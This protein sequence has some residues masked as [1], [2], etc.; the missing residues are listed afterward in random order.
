MRIF[1]SAA[2]I[3]SDLQAEKILRAFLARFPDQQI[4]IFGIGGPALRTLPG[5]KALQN[6]ESMRAMGFVEVLSRIFFFKQIQTRIVSELERHPPDV[7]LTF[8]Y[9]D[10]HFSLMKRLK[11]LSWF[12]S[13]LRICGIPPK[14]WVWR[15]GR[16][17][18]IAELYS[19][20]WVIFPFEKDFYQSHGI[21]VI[22]EGNPL[23]ADLVRNA[24]PK[25]PLIEGDEVRIAV[26]PGSREGELKAHLP[27]LGPTLTELSQLLGK[28]VHAEVPIPLG[29]NEA[30]V[31][32]ELISTDRVNYRLILGGSGEVLSRNSLGLIKSGTSTLEAAVLG[33]VPVIFYRMNPISEWIFRRV[34]HYTGPVGLPNILL[35]IHHRARS[36]FPEL[37]GGEA[38][39]DLLATAL[40]RLIDQPE[41][42]DELR[43]KGEALR[44]S[45]VP[46]SEVSKSIAGALSKWIENPPSSPLRRK[47]SFGIGLISFFWSS[48]N[49]LRRILRAVTGLS[50]PLL[51]VKSI[52]VG[53]LQA[54]GAGK[55]PMIIAIAREA[56]RRGYRVGIVSRGYKGN[57]SESVRLVGAKDTTLEIGDEPAEIREALPEVPLALSKDRNQAAHELLRQGVNL[58]LADDGYQNLKFQTDLTVILVTD[59][60]RDELPYRDFDSEALE[61]DFLVQ[62]KGLKASRFPHARTLTWKVGELPKTPLWLWTAIAD[63]MELLAFYEHQGLRFKRVITSPDHSYP[64]QEEIKA[65]LQ[66]AAENGALLA[67]TAKDSVKFDPAQRDQC[68][69]LRRTLQDSGFFQELFDRLQ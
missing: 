44:Q 66:A 35:G 6:A 19:G 48:L 39:P 50:S 64:S 38:R 30:E 56:L 23:I 7:I 1:V 60:H 34:V 52:L 51:P 11:K 54:G 10:F 67:I 3:S 17:R 31:S 25:T 32:R 8:D 36:V 58:I 21:P 45:L 63:P 40:F 65:L 9:P 41:A 33:C 59:A 68:L 37:L 13:S 46:G 26:L 20:V 27:L 15:K 57:Y 24:I 29:V 47:R 12:K 5:F 55:T 69:I 53:N 49:R 22:Y 14:V 62:T 18:Q 61:A 2:E 42:L 28:R 16:V 4:E 43:K